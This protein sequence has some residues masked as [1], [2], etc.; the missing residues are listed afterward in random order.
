[1][2]LKVASLKASL[3]F[4]AKLMHAECLW[5]CSAYFLDKTSRQ[6][7]ILR[8]LVHLVF[9]VAPCLSRAPKV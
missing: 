7:V 6:P 4:P 2:A 1:M 5:P 3:S 9:R 8:I